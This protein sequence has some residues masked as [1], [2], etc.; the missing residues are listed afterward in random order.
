MKYIWIYIIF[1]LVLLTVTGSAQNLFDVSKIN[2]IEIYFE[3]SDWDSIL[4]EY[5]KNVEGERLL[6]RVI[7][8][9]E[10]FE[11]AGIRYKGFSSYDKD[12]NKKPL[13]IQLDYIKSNQSYRG[14]ETLKLSNGWRDPSLIREV[15]AYEIARDYMPSSRANFVKVYINS[16]YHGIYSSAETVDKKFLKK[17]F[18]EN[19]GI[20][21]KGAPARIPGGF[22]FKGAADLRYVGTSETKYINS[23]DLKSDSGWADLI[24][25]CDI[26][27]N[28]VEE[29][30]TVF[31]VDLALWF[32]AFHN[33]L[34]SLDSPIASSR[35]F[36][37]YK[38]IN[39]IFQI[40]PWDLNMAFGTYTLI[41]YTWKN[42]LEDILRLDPLYHND[43]EKY[44]L[45]RQ[46][47]QNDQYQKI[48]LAHM[49]TILDEKFLS[50][51]YD[52]RARYLQDMIDQ[53]VKLDDKK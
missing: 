16:E 15:L 37:L 8:N 23:Y 6:G 50:N 34:V 19:E 18:F 33:L 44:N 51:W 13:N 30:E 20:F 22:G 14:I 31:N 36:Y 2:T 42:T 12:Y 27:N 47:L 9:G 28:R 1:S 26:L 45:V 46:L 38:N 41:N 24:E 25:L 10:T 4:H 52:D 7:I 32:L 53:D 11:S 39:G 48:Y 17:H 35:N 29:L 3:Q 5:W 40:I 43:S 21:I 49:R